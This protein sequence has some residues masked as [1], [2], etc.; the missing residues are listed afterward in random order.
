MLPLLLLAAA[1]AAPAPATEAA[2][3]PRANPTVTRA[4]R[5]RE[6][7][8]AW[9][10]DVRLRA[11]PLDPAVLTPLASIARWSWFGVR[12]AADVI[13]PAW[14]EPTAENAL[15][16]AVPRR[17]D[18][19]VLAPPGVGITPIDPD[20]PPACAPRAVAPGTPLRVVPRFY[21]DGRMGLL[22]TGSL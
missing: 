5:A 8:R 22:L 17:D 12:L 1:L 10:N 9:R 14:I 2:A 20:A 16:P 3:V 18:R 4:G 11:E 13:D 6:Q 19:C 15:V 7:R 21:R